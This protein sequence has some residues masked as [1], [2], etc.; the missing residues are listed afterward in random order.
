MIQKHSVLGDYPFRY[1]EFAENN[2]V[3]S[4]R[5]IVEEWWAKELEKDPER[6]ERKK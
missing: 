1:G 6:F 4:H 3:S 5:A 2:H